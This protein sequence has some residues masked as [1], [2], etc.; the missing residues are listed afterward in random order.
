[1][2]ILFKLRILLNAKNIFP[3]RKCR[4]CYLIVQVED[5]GNKFLGKTWENGWSDSV[6]LGK[7]VILKVLSERQIK[8]QCFP[9]NVENAIGHNSYGKLIK[10]YYYNCICEGT[11]DGL[12][13][14]DFSHRSVSKW[15]LA[16]IG[17]SPNVVIYEINI[18][19]AFF[20]WVVFFCDYVFARFVFFRR[21]CFFFFFS[22]AVVYFFC[23]FAVV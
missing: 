17:M 23:D 1:M 3:I 5:S 11:C 13:L 6:F 9:V 19:L 12:R 18:S 20:A 21:Q 14:A 15:L 10:K 4:T 2:W 22:L 8:R 16:A 7:T